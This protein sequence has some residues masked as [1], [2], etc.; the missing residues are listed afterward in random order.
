MSVHQ[1]SQ[2]HYNSLYQ[3]FVPELYRTALYL[4]GDSDAAEEVVRDTWIQACK[5]PAALLDERSASTEVFKVLLAQC[6]ERFGYTLYQE[7]TLLKDSVSS[8]TELVRILSKMGFSE[9]TLVV[10]IIV[11]KFCVGDAARILGQPGWLIELRLHHAVGKLLRPYCPA[12][13]LRGRASVC[14][15]S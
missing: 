14:V 3:Q 1:I 4:L 11:N 2:Q 7:D 9:R 12:E 15:K 5:N 10:L 13:S 8:V 6:D